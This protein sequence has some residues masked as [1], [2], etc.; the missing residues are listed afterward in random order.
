MCTISYPI[1]IGIL[2]STG[3][4]ENVCVRSSYSCCHPYLWDSFN[5]GVSFWMSGRIHPRRSLVLV[6]EH[7]DVH[8]LKPVRNKSYLKCIH[9]PHYFRPRYTSRD[10]LSN[11]L[12]SFSSL[13]ATTFCENIRPVPGSNRNSLQFR[14]FYAAVQDECHMF[15]LRLWVL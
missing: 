11:C 14:M 4:I 6:S 13:H 15:C 3:C 5:D 9:M 12:K 1:I 7:D 8:D 2:L 10:L